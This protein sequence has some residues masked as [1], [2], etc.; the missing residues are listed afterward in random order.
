[1]YG[2]AGALAM[3]GAFIAAGAALLDAFH[4]TIYLFGALLL[5]AAVKVLRHGDAQIHPDTNLAVRLIRR[6]IPSTSTLDGRKFFTQ[7][8]GQWL[9][10]PLLTVLILIESTDMIFAID[11]VPAIFAVTRDTFVVFTS[12]IFALLGM[13]ALYFLVAGAAQ[14]FMYLQTGLGIILAG[15]GIELLLTDL[16]KV[17]TWASLVFILGVLAVTC[18]LSWHATRRSP[19]AVGSPTRGDGGDGELP[20]AGGND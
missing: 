5:Y 8:D 14:R 11:S 2:I 3:R 17:P 9:A 15:V 4:V 1:M 20:D 16:C 6:V 10:T 19:V 13:R 18:G 12:N 7:A